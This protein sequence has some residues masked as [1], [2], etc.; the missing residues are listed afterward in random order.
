[1]INKSFLTTGVL[2]N[3][4]IPITI[5]LTNSNIKRAIDDFWINIINNLDQDY[6]IIILFR[7]EYDNNHI[8]TLGQLQKIN[9]NAYN[10]YHDYLVTILE[11]KS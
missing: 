9:K 4:K 7:V 5:T 1:M 11:L 6:S 3:Y 10:D 2:N 8:A